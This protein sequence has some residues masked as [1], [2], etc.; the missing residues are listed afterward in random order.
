MPYLLYFLSNIIQPVLF[1]TIAIPSVLSYNSHL[2]Y[3][4]QIIK[5]KMREKDKH[6]NL[7]F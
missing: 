7:Y 3:T 5:N 4:Q 2:N 6:N 1:S